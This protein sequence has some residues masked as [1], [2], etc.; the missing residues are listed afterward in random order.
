MSRKREIG[1]GGDDD[2]F[3]TLELILE[4]AENK[5]VEVL[6]VTMGNHTTVE[7]F[8]IGVS[9]AIKE[10]FAVMDGSLVFKNAVIRSPQWPQGKPL[11]EFGVRNKDQVKVT[12][13]PGIYQRLDQVPTATVRVQPQAPP[14]VTRAFPASRPTTPRRAWSDAKDGENAETA[15]GS[16]RI[17]A[18]VVRGFKQETGNEEM[19]ITDDETMKKMMEIGKEALEGLT[20]EEGGFA[21]SEDQKRLRA[22]KQMRT[23]QLE[24]LAKLEKDLSLF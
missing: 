22:L 5:M 9:K 8:M 19:M 18:A 11:S 3:A 24:E 20:T 23:E 15:G 14:R 12:L 16:E 6:D 4:D 17:E 2:D 10:E 7:Q 21:E 13:N 1:I